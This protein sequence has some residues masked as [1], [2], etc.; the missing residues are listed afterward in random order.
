MTS[1]RLL[2]VEDTEDDAALVSVALTRA[3]FDLYSRRV[4]TAAALRHELDTEEWDLVIA[5]YAMPGFSGAKALHIVRERRADLPFIFVSGTGGEDTAVAAMRTGAHDYIMRGNLSRLAPAVERELREAAARRERLLA[6]QRVAY[7]AYHD[8]LTDL[9]NRALFHDRLQQAILRSHRDE[10]GLVVLLIDLDGFREIN[11]A[12]GHHAGDQVLQE[13]ASRLRGALRAS[14]TVARLGGDEF[15]VLLPATDVNRAELAARKIL[16]DLEHAFVADERP[17]MVTA[18]IGIAGCPAHASTSDELL[19]KADSAMY[20]AKGDGCGCAVY[21]VTRDQ[22]VY[23]RVS[24]ATAL[25]Q[26]LDAR[27]F[28]VDYQP[29]VHLHTGTVIGVESLVRWNHPERGRLL[30]DDFIRVAERT[31]LVNPLTA[32]V[33]DRAF[34]EWPASQL[35]AGCTIAVNVSPRSLH[36]SAFPGRVSELLDGYGTPPGSLMLEITENMVMS[37]P[38]GAARCLH[39]LHEMG[40]NLAIDDFGRGYSSLSYLRQLPVDQ[41]KIDRSFQIGLASGEDETLVR[42]MIDLAHNLGMMVVAEGV[43]TEGVYQQLVGMGCDAVQGFFINRPA[44]AADVAG[45]IG[46]RA[47]A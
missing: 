14:D 44:P 34:S 6:N 13:V 17:L 24:M 4:G 9:P 7:L 8:S 16:H 45:W 2:Q 1:I 46:R 18:S 27:Q 33:L 40:V 41:L 37:D 19:Q 15:A 3:G 36:H 38:D 23:Q 32:F 30:P 35:P 12:L 25:R 11:D 31:G 20:V 47:P 28:E 22:R 39:Q 10:R 21:D 26:A 29:I 43:E 5:D 42:C